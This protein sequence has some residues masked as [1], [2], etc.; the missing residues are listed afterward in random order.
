M[1]IENKQADYD[2]AITMP[3]HLD[4]T[5]SPEMKEHLSEIISSA[6]K[7]TLDFSDTRLVS[8]AGLRVLLQ[9]QKNVEKSAKSMKFINVSA[10]VME[11]FDMTG[12]TKIFDIV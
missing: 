4:T 5:T 12:V 7:I 2:R 6:D 10:E 3:D 8:S 1:S 9:A 11:V